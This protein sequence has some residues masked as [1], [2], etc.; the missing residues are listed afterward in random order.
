MSARSLFG[1][2]REGK[3]VHAASV[4]TNLLLVP[5]LLSGL[6]VEGLEGH[7]VSW[8]GRRRLFGRAGALGMLALE[9]SSG[10]RAE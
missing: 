4:G 2:S 3:N 7:W 5:V 10:L 6:N 8:T 1:T 9:V